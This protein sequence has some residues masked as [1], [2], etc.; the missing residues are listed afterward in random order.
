[1]VGTKVTIGCRATKMLK[2]VNN[3]IRVEMRDG[4]FALSQ[5]F[6]VANDFDLYSRSFIGK[7]LAYDV[8]MN[9]VLSEAEEVINHG[10]NKKLPPL[11]SM[12]PSLWGRPLQNR[13]EARKP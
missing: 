10:K 9:L 6:I 5:I 13:F 8:Q 7:L 3:L 12:L 2:Y 1:M 11:P 4:Y